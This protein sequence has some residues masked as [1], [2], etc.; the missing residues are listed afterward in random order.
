MNKV[1]NVRIN[2]LINYDHEEFLFVFFGEE[3]IDITEIEQLKTTEMDEMLFNDFKNKLKE[4]EVDLDDLENLN[5]FEDL[6]DFDCKLEDIEIPDNFLDDYKGNGK[7]KLE[8]AVMDYADGVEDAFN[9][10]YLHYRPILDRW[11]K[12]KNNEELGAELLDIV[13]LSAVKT[14]KQ[15]RGAK[16]NTYFWKCAHNYMSCNNSKNNAQKRAHNKN[17]AS[18]NEKKVYKGDSTEMELEKIIEDKNSTNSLREN[19]LINSIESLRDCLKETEIYTLLKLIENYTL[20]EIG[21]DLG[22]TA[23]AVCLSLK[24]IAQKPAAAK[25]LK[26]ILTN[27]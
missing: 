26:D 11:G 9:Y 14:F 17:M 24:R 3:T 4:E 18:L 13:L 23:A 12:R 6:D 16:F 22:I 1:E 27:R 8:E 19:E 21:N 25:K 10:I 2:G 20:Q 15:D 5:D 7:I